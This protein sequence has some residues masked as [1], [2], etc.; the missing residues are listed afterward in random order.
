MTENIQDLLIFFIE[1]QRYG[2]Q[3]SD[4]ERIIRAV[5]ITKIPD[6]PEFIEGIIDY[7]GEV[8]ATINIRKFFRYPEQE[9]RLSDRFIIV[10]TPKRKLALIVD[11]VDDVLSPNF[12]DLYNSQYINSGLKFIQI[13]RDDD[14]I[15]FICDVE[16]MLDESED[17]ELGRYLEANFS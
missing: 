3:L 11:E 15:I 4:I 1:E 13:L 17:I 6:A 16:N 8:I 12:Q 2:I 5:A 9:L 10:K 14:G 7:Y